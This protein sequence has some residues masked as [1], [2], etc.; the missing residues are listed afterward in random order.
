[1]ASGGDYVWSRLRKRLSDG[2]QKVALR[3]QGYT[4]VLR[5]RRTAQQAADALGVAVGQITK[6]IQPSPW[7]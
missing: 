6:S 3:R 2:V 5:T 7:L 1:V 4:P